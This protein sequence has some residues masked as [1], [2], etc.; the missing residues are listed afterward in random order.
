LG[1]S[2]S[3][4]H[5]QREIDPASTR[6]QPSAGS[7]PYAGSTNDSQVETDQHST[8]LS[9]DELALLPLTSSYRIDRGKEL[10]VT[11]WKDLIPEGATVEKIAEASYAEVYRISI[12]GQNSII[13]LM[14]LQI[15]S[16]PESLTSHST[17]KVETV[18]SEVRL[19]N[20]LTESPGFVEFKEA[21][22]VKGKPCKM[23]IQA[24][25]RW[26]S[27]NEDSQF[28]D[29]N[30]FLPNTLFLAI[31]L[32]DAGKVLDETPLQRIDQV[33]DIF[34]GVVVALAAA[35]HMFSFE[36]CVCDPALASKL[37]ACSIV[38]SMK[39]T[40]VSNSARQLLLLAQPRSRSMDSVALA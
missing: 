9:P 6:T 28:P 19:M 26:S 30:T 31:E 24:C 8:N 18:V 38:I 14:Q 16:D 36:V 33:W 7:P 11:E 29:P 17:L 32:G 10:P 39:I 25:E 4:N 34:I 23:M 40:S 20:A 37:T 12:D 22:L 1:Y 13:K 35:E 15:P 3:Q 2:P 5:S 27:T 21:H